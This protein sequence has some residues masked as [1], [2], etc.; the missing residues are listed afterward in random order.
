M[1]IFKSPIFILFAFILISPVFGQMARKPS[2]TREP[3][4]AMDEKAGFG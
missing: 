3:A 4:G 1:K 2:P